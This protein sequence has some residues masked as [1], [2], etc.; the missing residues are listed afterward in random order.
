MSD[1]NDKDLE[2]TR[3][4]FT[5]LQGTAPEG[6]VI[7]PSHMPKLT[8]DQAWTVVWYLGNKYWQPTD[9]VERCDVCGE[10]YHSWCEGE[11]IDC[12]PPPIFFC[13][14]CREGHEAVEKH[15]I[16]RGLERS[17]RRATRVANK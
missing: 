14:N 2:N 13:G 3:E 17:K 1:K 9:A 15:R 11:T 5:F 4:L 6:Y 12:A 10:L 7:E 16:F 8:P